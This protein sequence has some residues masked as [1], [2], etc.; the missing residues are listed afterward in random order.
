L[1]LEKRRSV[2]LLALTVLLSTPVLSSSCNDL[3]DFALG[4]C[5]NSVLESGE[6]CEP[7]DTNAVP[8]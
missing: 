3:G 4:V 2:G 7:G 5:G 8:S 1:A 6:D